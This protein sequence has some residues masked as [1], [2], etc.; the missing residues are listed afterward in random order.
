M[1]AKGG[2]EEILKGILTGIG[3]HNRYSE[4]KGLGVVTYGQLEGIVERVI[5]GI[6]VYEGE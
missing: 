4:V 5:G 1:K 2:F 6:K 3:Q